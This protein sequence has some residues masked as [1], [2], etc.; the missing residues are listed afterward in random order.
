MTVEV[1]I[2]VAETTG[3]ETTDRAT[4]VAAETTITPP[5][6]AMATTKEVTVQNVEVTVMPIL[7]VDEG[8]ISR[9]QLRPQHMKGLSGLKVQV[10]KT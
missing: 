3:A 8:I 10:T 6:G 9:V 1:S 7:K 4:N 2:I 5:K